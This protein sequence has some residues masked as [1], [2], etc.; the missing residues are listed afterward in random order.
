MASWA[1]GEEIT[2]GHPHQEGSQPAATASDTTE[3][4]WGQN[5]AES[6]S[7]LGWRNV[8]ED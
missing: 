5:G 1:Q 2:T 7:P 6:Y 3:S 8:Q 4:N